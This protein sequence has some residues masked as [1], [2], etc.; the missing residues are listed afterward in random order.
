MPYRIENSQFLISAASPNQFPRNPEPEIALVGRSNVGKSSLFNR[1]TRISDLAKTSRTPGKTQ[2]INFF[3]LELHPPGSGR[4]P[5]HLT[6]ADLPGYGYAKVPPKVR[7][8]WQRLVD[9]YFRTRTQLSLVLHLVD[10]RHPPQPADFVLTDLLAEFDAPLLLIA[11]KADKL[12]RNQRKKQEKVIR[13]ELELGEDAYVVITS[14]VTGEGCDEILQVVAET[15]FPD[16]I[17]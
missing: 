4:R 10:L 13:E 16:K 9:C 11:T 17:K 8:A 2:L 3:S 5:F 14:A 7:E 6:A 15:L 1:L 12:S